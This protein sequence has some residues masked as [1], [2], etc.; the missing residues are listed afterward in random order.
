M[1]HVLLALV[2]STFTTSARAEDKL[3]VWVDAA[4]EGEWTIEAL[5]DSAKDLRGRIKGK[6]WQRARSEADADVVLTVVNRYDA[7]NGV[8]T[9]TYNNFSGWQSSEDKDRVVEVQLSVGGEFVKEFVGRCPITG[10]GG[11]WSAAANDA[12]K[13]I[14]SFLKDNIARVREMTKPPGD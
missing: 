14:E 2:I 8:R 4:T 3:L 9:T 10:F 7:G 5:E 11:E 6:F 12:K 13:Q 1:K